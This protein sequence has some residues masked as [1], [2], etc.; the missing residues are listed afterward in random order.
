MCGRQNGVTA[1]GP[2]A[3]PR[4]RDGITHQCGFMRLLYLGDL[5]LP[6]ATGAG[7]ARGGGAG[8]AFLVLTQNL[9]QS[10]F[11]GDSGEGLHD[12]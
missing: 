12:K 4:V 5:G 7:P 11:R 2:P 10:G 3:G 1:L 8:S 6:Q 9:E